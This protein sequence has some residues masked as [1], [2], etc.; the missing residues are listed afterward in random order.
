MSAKNKNIQPPP[1]TT[2]SYK[3]RVRQNKV[4][5]KQTSNFKLQILTYRIFN[6]Y[7]YFQDDPIL[8][9]DF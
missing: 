8:T 3:K 6:M 9:F 4:S 7:I 1:K 2:G 5:F